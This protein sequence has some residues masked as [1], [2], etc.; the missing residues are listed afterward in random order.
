MLQ[1]LQLLPADGINAAFKIAGLRHV[2]L[3]ALKSRYSLGGMPGRVAKP[4]SW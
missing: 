3:A 1:F 2:P 4:S